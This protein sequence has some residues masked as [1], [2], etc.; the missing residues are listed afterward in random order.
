MPA[1]SKQQY[2]FMKSVAQGDIKAPG[3]S[4]SEAREYTKGQLPKYS[5]IKSL[6][7]KIR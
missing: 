3:L 6:I 4:Q 1:K 7:D 2:K 5:K